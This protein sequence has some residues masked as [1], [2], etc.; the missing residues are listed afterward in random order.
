M[1]SK[2]GVLFPSPDWAL[3]TI[4]LAKVPVFVGALLGAV[5]VFTCF[6]RW[7]LKP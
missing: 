4:N 5:L 2:P 3:N 7:P 6:H 1:R